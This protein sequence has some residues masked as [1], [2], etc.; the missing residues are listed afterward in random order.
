MSCSTLQI[1]GLEIGSRNDLNFSNPFEIGLPKQSNFKCNLE[2]YLLSGWSSEMCRNLTSIEKE[3]RASAKCRFS[4]FWLRSKCSICSYQLNIWY[5]GHV[6]PSILNWFLIGEKVQELA[7]AYSRVGLALQYRQD[8]PTS[9]I[10]SESW[11]D[12]SARVLHNLMAQF[13]DV[14]YPEQYTVL[15]G[16]DNFGL[17]WN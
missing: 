13:L 11:D 8:R 5:G 2:I 3:T 15:S 4:A 16:R 14:M 10:T 9:P 7:Q 1:L 12:T 6:P 17:H